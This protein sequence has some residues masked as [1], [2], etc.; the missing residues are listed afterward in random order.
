MT[1][2]TWL[3]SWPWAGAA[4]PDGNGYIVPDAVH[5]MRAAAWALSDYRVSTV[6][7]GAIWFI[8]LPEVTAS[9]G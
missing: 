2:A 4:T 7:G 3:A 8:K 1:L 5:E 6:T 9:R